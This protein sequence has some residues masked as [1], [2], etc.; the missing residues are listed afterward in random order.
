MKL[1]VIIIAKNA[2][3]HIVDAIESVKEVADEVIVVDND[4][5]DRTREIAE[6]LKAKVYTLEGLNFAKLRNLGLE[7]ARG[8]WVIY[9]DTDERVT[10]ELI[11]NI[12]YF[13]R[14]SAGQIS[15]IN[16]EIAAFKVKRKNFYFGNH[17]WPYIEK[18]ERLFK[19]SVL[20]GWRGE[21]HESPEF[22]GRVAQIEGFLLHYTHRNLSSMLQKTIEWSKIEAELRLKS[23]HSKMT[24]WRFFR[25]MLT[26]FFDSYVRQ[27]G[28][29]AGTIGIME[30]MYQA[31]SM[32]ITYA[33]LWEMQNVKDQNNK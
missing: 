13:G 28:W 15:N 8:D 5:T 32:F 6:Y 3:D 33:R 7:K 16:N 2:E 27:E 22:T 12:K 19:R 24:W 29:R 31:F 23:G 20:N 17:E 10:S 18:L 30:S 1:S 21:L 26:A 11:S 25:V 14:L 4:S 9:I